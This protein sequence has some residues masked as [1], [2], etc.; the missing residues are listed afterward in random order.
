M[1]AS[2][3]FACESAISDVQWIVFVD[4]ISRRMARQKS[5]TLLYSVMIDL[6]HFDRPFFATLNERA[7]KEFVPFTLSGAHWY[8][9]GEPSVLVFSRRE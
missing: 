8:P 6:F 4:E 5:F 2:T 9:D 7:R 3:H 1:P